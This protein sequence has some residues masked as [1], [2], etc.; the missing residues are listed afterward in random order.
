MRLALVVLVAAIGVSATLFAAVR[1]WRANR[2]GAPPELVYGYLALMV[3]ASAVTVLA[4][5]LV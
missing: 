3:A 5:R 2:R 1:M 4:L